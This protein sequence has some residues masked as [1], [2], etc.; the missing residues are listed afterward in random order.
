MHIEIDDDDQ[1]SLDACCSWLAQRYFTTDKLKRRLPFVNFASNYDF[2]SL[3]CDLIAGFTVAFTVLPQALAF[4]LLAGLPPKY[5]LYSSFVGCFV[6][7]LLG[8]CPQA[9]IGPTSILSVLIAPIVQYGGIVYA[10]LL[11]FYT[12]VCLI[13]L[14]A[15]NF[16][17]VLDF[18]SFPVISAFGTSA[19]ITILASQ[20]R[21]FF[22][23]Q[24]AS[25][26]FWT[27]VVGFVQHFGEIQLFDTLL[28][29][30]SLLLLLLLKRGSEFQLS[31]DSLDARWRNVARRLFNSL[32]FFLASARNAVV[33]LISISIAST[34]PT[35]FHLAGAVDG[36]LP[37]W[38]IPDLS[39]CSVIT[40]HSDVDSSVDYV[41]L[42][43][44]R[45]DHSTITSDS[46]EPICDSWVVILNQLSSSVFVLV[47][48]ALL[49]AT[50]VV[51]SFGGAGKMD[52]TQEM[53]ALGFANLIG[54]FI[55]SMPVTASFSRSA[56]NRSAGVRTPFAG[57]ACGCIVMF[58]IWKLP[59]LF[60]RVPQSALSAVIVA[61]IYPMVRPEEL[62]L[63]WRANRID[64]I[65]YCLTAAICLGS[66]L[67]LGVLVGVLF[68]LSLLLYQMARPKVTIVSRRTPHGSRFLYVK[69]D[70]SVFFPSVEY[71]KV[72]IHQA[73]AADLGSTIEKTCVRN[74]KGNRNDSNNVSERDSIVLVLNNWNSEPLVAVV[75][76]GEHMFRADATFAVVS[77]CPYI[78]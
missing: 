17:F 23:V 47:L 25:N 35:R 21:A 33:V 28:A 24:Y 5:G 58:A 6:Y 70:R 34:Y 36:G 69:P 67:Q 49:E 38:Q 30:S 19:A 73:L 71:V 8:T 10:T 44:N 1:I 57:I 56:V 66:D 27:H 59:F 55:Q 26:D 37:E 65:P 14:G 15:L 51:R 48:V 39:S 2:D 50:A 29:T 40:D 76:D 52:A 42:A 77:F 68:S 45:S 3:R 16:G 31:L 11:S 32:W 54:S 78:C 22:G 4:A 41:D 75:I 72:K 12:G 18:V 60:E 20:L 74:S 7:A 64:L 63:I 46:G 53:L 13:L 43:L 9:A 61:A 62:R